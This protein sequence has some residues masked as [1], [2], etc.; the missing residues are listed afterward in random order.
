MLPSHLRM[1][2][3]PRCPAASPRFRRIIVSLDFSAECDD[4]LQSLAAVAAG[5]DVML[6]F[7]YIIDVF[8]ETFVH[9]NGRRSRVSALSKEKITR[10]LRDRLGDA[11]RFDESECASSVLVGLPALALARHV[12]RTAADLVVL[13][14]R[15]RERH[16]PPTWVGLA[17]TRLFR[18]PAWRRL[19]LRPRGNLRSIE[20]RDAAQAASRR[21]KFAGRAVRGR[22]TE[23]RIGCAAPWAVADPRA[24]A[25]D[26]ANPV[27]SGRP[28][29]CHRLI[30]C[31]VSRSRLP[32]FRIDDF[33]EGEL[34]ASA[35]FNWR[36]AACSRETPFRR[37]RS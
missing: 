6:E 12:E 18:D 11:T 35:S 3:P 22:H 9:C 14:S 19:H 27:A 34:R 28:V 32:H 2:V 26:P 25:Q 23:R 8:T 16:A 33:F 15:H 31:S 4:A 36:R 7:V 30:A 5:T 29:G 17:A 37:A 24:S 20:A 21:A 1:A 13:G 10:A